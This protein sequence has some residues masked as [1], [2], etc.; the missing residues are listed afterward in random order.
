M[1]FAWGIFMALIGAALRLLAGN[2]SASA[3]LGHM[4]F[5][6]GLVLDALV[7][8]QRLRMDESGAS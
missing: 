2:F 6:F 4:M 3:D 8:Y 5:A 1:I 7:A